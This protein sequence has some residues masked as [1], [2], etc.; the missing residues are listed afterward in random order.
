MPDPISTLRPDAMS[1]F[2]RWAAIAVAIAVVG[3][4]GY[5]LVRGFSDTGREL[6]QFPWLLAVPVL[7]LTLVNYGLRYVKWHYLIGQLGVKISHK[8]DAPIFLAGLAMVIS[9]AKAGEVVKPY[10]VRT[11]TGVPMART[12]PALVAERGTDGIAVVAL[13]AIGVSTYAAEA[14]HI[15]WITIGCIA[16]GLA[17]IT[18]EPIPRAALRLLSRLPLLSRF[19][20]RL[21]EAYTATRTVLAPVPLLVTVVLSMLAWFAECIG[22]WMIFQGLQTAATL[23]QA[24]FLYAFSTVFGAP[25]PGGLGMADVA[26]AEGALQVVPGITEGQA[27]A[28]SLLVRLA[29]LWFG[30]VLGALALLRME[31]VIKDATR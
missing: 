22:A 6:A 14:S 19:T 27:L 3:W 7:L 18:I 23:D 15:I 11:I 20:D 1:R 10:L 5:A 16:L 17:A 25:S 12:V 9:P 4:V 21:E 24:T 30:V 31:H 26:L 13:A 29:T 8:H 28:A 2:R